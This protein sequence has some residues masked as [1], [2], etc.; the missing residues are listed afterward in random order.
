MLVCFS[1]W[2]GLVFMCTDCF[3]MLFI[4]LIDGGSS[5]S[6]VRLFGARWRR[7][8]RCRVGHA[9]QPAGRAVSWWRRHWRSSSVSCA[10]QSR[11]WPQAPQPPLTSQPPVKPQ[12]LTR[13]TAKKASPRKIASKQHSPRYRG[14]GGWYLDDGVDDESQGRRSRHG[15]VGYWWQVHSA[16]NPLAQ[17]QW[18][19]IAQDQ[20]HYIDVYTECFC[21]WF[22]ALLALISCTSGTDFLHFWHWFL[23]DAWPTEN[24]Q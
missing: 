6:R 22:L 17:D 1:Q 8:W 2:A 7:G 18:H 5:G 14:K 4:R 21:H 24:V 13:W 16:L 20:W 23:I 10:S 15:R 19:Y 11:I 3:S 9:N 12:P